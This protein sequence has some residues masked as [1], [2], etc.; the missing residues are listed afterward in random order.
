MKAS[1]EEKL[2]ERLNELAEIERKHD[3]TR[4]EVFRQWAEARSAQ[5]RE[6]REPSGPFP[7]LRD[8]ELEDALRKEQLLRDRLADE[9]A[10]QR[11]I[12]NMNAENA[13]A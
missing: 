1:S 2:V 12:A 9:P 7:L 6:G 10:R 3:E 4:R 13:A 11:L 5:I 8:R